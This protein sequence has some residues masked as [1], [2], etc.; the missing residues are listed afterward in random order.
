MTSNWTPEWLA[1]IQERIKAKMN[2]IQ[3]I[4][5]RF[6]EEDTEMSGGKSPRTKGYSFE[7][8]CVNIAKAAGYDA[9]RTPCSK[10]PDLRLDNRPISCKRRKAIPKWIEKELENHD[11]ILMRGDRGKI[12]QIKYWEPRRNNGKQRA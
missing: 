3:P 10:Y 6:L 7:R 5:K 8:E 12:V 4:P 11:F 1:V 9:K 2:R